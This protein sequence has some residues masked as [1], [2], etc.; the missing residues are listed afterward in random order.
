[1]VADSTTAIQDKKY[2]QVKI[3]DTEHLQIMAQADMA[4]TTED[5][6]ALAIMVLILS[7]AA[8]VYMDMAIVLIWDLMAVAMVVDRHICTLAPTI[9]P[10]K[11]LQA[12]HLVPIQDLHMVVA[13]ALPLL[14]RA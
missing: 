13:Q 12:L 9:L 10:R 6:L 7:Q 8:M 14:L 4:P 3:L 1:M 5:L 2:L 11:L